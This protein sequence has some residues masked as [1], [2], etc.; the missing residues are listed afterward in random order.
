FFLALILAAL[1]VANE[2]YDPSVVTALHVIALAPTALISALLVRRS[3]PGEVIA[4]T[5]ETERRKW[6]ASSL[7]MMLIG[8]LSVINSRTDIIMLGWFGDASAIGIYS[9][10]VRGSEL[11]MMIMMAAH[12]ALNPTMASLF[13]AGK[14]SELNRLSVRSGRLILLAST[15]L[16]IGLII[17]GEWFLAIFGPEFTDG[18]ITLAI[19]CIGNLGALAMGPAAVVLVMT[20]HER[21]A[22]RAI[23]ITVVTNILLNLV[24]IPI[25]GKEGAAFATALNNFARAALLTYW[26]FKLVGIGTA[27]WQRESRTFD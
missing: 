4:S 21:R 9:V 18:Q 19:L 1:L 26:T 10:A 3:L 11:T 15:P 8:G 13:A 2:V 17:W 7:A 6:L 25:Y 23:A 24:L 14:L 22:A 5:P 27:A 12:A 16:V 20:G